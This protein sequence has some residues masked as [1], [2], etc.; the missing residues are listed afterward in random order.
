MGWRRL[1]VCTVMPP[2]EIPDTE[3]EADRLGRDA[4]DAL[5]LLVSGN[6]EAG[7]ELYDR[8]LRTSLG[9][10]LPVGLHLLLLEG[11][12]KR[13]AAVRLRELALRRGGNIVL[14]GVAIEGS[15]EESAEAYEALLE[16]GHF[17]TRMMESYLMLL[18]RLG[19][20]ERIAELCH[21]ELL[22][23]AVRVGPSPAELAGRVQEVLLQEEEAAA[24]AEAAQ[25]VRHQRQISPLDKIGDPAISTL[26]SLLRDETAEY[27]RAWA[28]SSHA[29]ARYV[30]RAF[31][32]EAWALIS[33]GSGYN[34][35]HIHHRGWATGVYYPGGLN[36]GETG[37]ELCIGA[38]E[39]VS[40]AR[41][42]WPAATFRPEPGL[43]VLIPSYYTHWTVP[44]GRPGLRTA[45]AFDIVRK[46]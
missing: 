20:V 21:Q 37:G 2:P 38:P 28:G 24:Y 22:L 40:G 4:R 36:W 29:L 44:L 9:H 16:R 5:A 10:T 35:P 14:K 39:A 18:T 34:V 41:A 33:R 1:A 15:A 7:L 42:G 46:G 45:I 26:L 27:L 17:N 6:C 32:L 13:D 12:G 11:A 25:S 3:A 19:R 8:A 30:P 43:L 23:R 31:R